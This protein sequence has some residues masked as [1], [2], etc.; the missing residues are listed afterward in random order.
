MTPSLTMTPTG[1]TAVDLI[2]GP[3]R[4][5]RDVSIEGFL[6]VPTFE[7][8][9]AES[10]DTEGGRLVS[11]H[12][13]NPVSSGSVLITGTSASDFWTNARTWQQ[14]VGAVRKVGG[15]FAYTPEG[16]TQVTYD[17][18]SI[19]LTSF[20][21]DNALIAG[22]RAPSNFEVTFRPYG[23]LAA[24]TQYSAFPSA[25][26]IF[27]IDIGNRTYAS[28]VGADAPAM[29][30]RLGAS[31]T[32]DQ[33]GNARNGTGGGG[34]T[35]GGA[36]GALSNDTDAA[37]TFDGT[38]D[39]VVSTY[40]A[41]WADSAV[42]GVEGWFYLTDSTA[43]RTLFAGDNSSTAPSLKILSGGSDVRLRIRDNDTGATSSTTWTAAWPGNNQ[44]VH[45][46]MIWDTSN[47]TME[48]WINGVSQ[49]IKTGLTQTISGAGNVIVGVFGP[50]FTQPFKGNVDEVAVYTTR[51]KGERIIA[52]YAAGAS[53][54]AVTGSVSGYG[55]LTIT[56]QASTNR[57]HVEWGVEEN[58]DPTNP[59][60]LLLAST[61]LDSSFQGV[62]NTR[63][64]AFD[65]IGAGNTTL[66]AS[67]G[68]V[69]V[70]VAGTGQMPHIGRWRIRPRVYQN[71]TGTCRVRLSWRVGKS[72][73]FTR[74]A[75]VTLGLPGQWYEP[76]LGLVNIPTAL[77]GTQSWE[78]WIESYSSVAGDTL[79][80]NYVQFIPAT[81][82]GK[83]RG[84]IAAEVA[85]SYSARDEFDQA[86]GNVTGKTLP[87]GGTW[88]GAGDADDAAVEAT[89]HTLQ[90]TAVSDAD[91]STGRFLTASSPTLT[92]TSVQ[93]DVKWSAQP[94]GVN[95]GVLARYVDTSNW[96]VFRLVQNG[97]GTAT[98][99]LDKRVAGTVTNLVIAA[100]SVFW[101]TLNTFYTLRL[102]IDTD[103]NWA[104]WATTTGS[105]LTVPYAVGNDSVFATGGTL[106]SGKAG[107]YDANTSATA[108]TRTY[109]NF[110]AWVPSVNP[111]VINSG[112][113]LQIDYQSA[114]REPSSGTAWGRVPT[115]EG[116]Y[117][118]IPQAG[119]ENKV[120]RLVV[121]ARSFDIDQ[122]ASSAP[123]KLAADLS[124]TPRV[125]L[126]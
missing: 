68:P 110:A 125:A 116:S 30:W 6:P 47:D 48:L 22:F 8:V 70:V 106:A 41:F 28:V 89:G 13:Q 98:P 111:H 109:D 62:G 90:R 14:A 64:G 37:T 117:L 42:R 49:G 39:R 43:D 97:D 120:S 93:A 3:I 95:L 74:N 27:G 50:T 79:D 77:V 10:V 72:D 104:V 34:I 17:I 44:W 61:Y 96:A 1:G 60:P 66:R 24:Q 75:W 4:L 102:T 69:S 5:L 23:R 115:Y 114:L 81:R 71:G 87:V 40:N 107:L 20:P 52:H 94:S 63:T 82:Y 12:S 54:L 124:V 9:Y 15:T 26:P 88:S 121:K 38:D 59:S 55:Q 33:S 51:L 100:P 57:N 92:S 99:R 80:V 83:A 2:A 18:E 86:A 118:K 31:G 16:G 36:T 105:P 67:L 19:R 7:E 78:G 108:S 112:K 91:A 113:R 126:L 53:R 45:V 119:N 101:G 58:Y 25:H 11:S 21:Q 65:P 32:T 123:A 85:S 84:P 35:I 46:F 76:D 73:A 29:Y 56:D 103:G 122:V